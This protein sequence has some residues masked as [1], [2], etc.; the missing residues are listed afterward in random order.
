[1]V[2]SFLEE[3]RLILAGDEDRPIN[4]SRFGHWSI[5][6][7]LWE[8]THHPEPTYRRKHLRIAHHDGSEW[9]PL[10]LPGLR[11]AQAPR[12]NET[13]PLRIGFVSG[14]H[15]EL[16]HVCDY[17]LWRHAEE[18]NAETDAD[19]ERLVYTRLSETLQS[20]EIRHFH[21]LELYHTGLAVV[22]VAAYRALMDTA[23][24]RRNLTAEATEL[25][26]VPRL[27]PRD[28]RTSLSWLT[29]RTGLRRADLQ[30]AEQGLAE[31]P[32]LFRR[33]PGTTRDGNADQLWH[34]LPERPFRAAEADLL[35]RLYPSAKPIVDALYAQAQ[36]RDGRHWSVQ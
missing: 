24:R 29:N 14:R 19:L 25:W 4:V 5:A 16:D 15:P 8:L 3:A 32:H 18:R 33:E 9:R 31:F 13:I 28:P 7:G 23:A 11:S 22:T 36:Y 1:M 2:N 27:W 6:Q 30:R 35:N 21:V 17:F 12:S 20:P 26:V 34:W 10:T